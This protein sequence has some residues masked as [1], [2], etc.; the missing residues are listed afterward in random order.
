MEEHSVEDCYLA[1]KEL[2][3]NELSDYEYEHIF[4]DN[5]STDGT[6]EILKKIAARD[7][8]V[9][10]IINSRNFGCA[11]SFYNAM[12]AATGDAVVPCLSVDLQDPETQNVAN[13][14]DNM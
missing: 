10:I 14:M 11:N 3:E 13:D 6:V 8:R 12:L 2:F 5:R 4:A 9:K 7:P 1:V